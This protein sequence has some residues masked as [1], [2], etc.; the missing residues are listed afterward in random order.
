VTS[1]KIFREAIT[2][3]RMS[4]DFVTGFQ[5]ANFEDFGKF[6][7]KFMKNLSFEWLIQGHL[8]QDD[9]IKIT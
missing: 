7:D 3:Q 4:K 6:K 1:F 8:T 9:A 2:G 5:K